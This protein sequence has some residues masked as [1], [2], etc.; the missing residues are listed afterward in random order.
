MVSPSQ[1]S[2]SSG[3]DRY[4][5]LPTSQEYLRAQNLTGSLEQLSNFE[6]LLALPLFENNIQPVEAVSS[7]IESESLNVEDSRERSEE[8]K[9]RDPS[10]SPN[11]V[12]FVPQY[13][14]LKPVTKIEP[15][16]AENL[17]YQRKPKAEKVDGHSRLKQAE[18]NSDKPTSHSSN[19]KLQPN[20]PKAGANTKA[21]TS[22]V[23]QTPVANQP[24]TKRT[25]ID[26][27]TSKL[28]KSKAELE[29][30]ETSDDS[31]NAP[32]SER[33]T[34]SDSAVETRVV[35]SAERKNQFQNSSDDYSA[36]DETNSQPEENFSGNGAVQ[37]NR[38]SE[39]LE[40]IRHREDDSSNSQNSEEAISSTALNGDEDSETFH[41]DLL[42]PKLASE[43]S[44]VELVDAI[45]AQPSVVTAV[46]FDSPSAT[47]SGI[48]ATS[49]LSRVRETS[50]PVVIGSS[51]AT[52]GA[53]NASVGTSGGQA[54]ARSPNGTSGS[55]STGRPS[56]TP[57]QE[58]KI[59]QRV[60]RGMEQ[61][62]NGSNQVRLRLHPPEL[63]TLQVTIRI[64]AQQ[65]AGLIEVEHVAARDALQN[66]LPQ[67][68]ARLADQGL[69]VQQFEI[70]VVDPTQFSQGDQLGGT[71]HNGSQQSADQREERRANNYPD[72]LR[73]RID[74]QEPD[75]SRSPTRLWTR[76]HGQIDL[77][78]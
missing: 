41:S 19:T 23:I 65:V 37:R 72:R 35:T 13:E 56:L 70:R 51:D 43:P 17:D 30:R 55:T 54:N 9:E 64:E 29:S 57:Y 77:R 4:R 61:L 24:L 8:T 22:E 32:V 7:K 76:T 71:W 74:T 63:G 58:Q 78:V 3:N 11:S 60:L 28:S 44:Q 59:L 42:S 6:L 25:E 20:D 15:L 2:A 31:R 33:A 36:P 49:G 50:I 1:A 21:D 18:Q 16:R 69:N 75:S 40:N 48:S 73:N 52:V 14:E 66:N 5:S 38:R 34:G 68:Q 62:A 67:L 45:E 12:V 53:M 47:Q 46:A 39:R 10:E 27:S 26:D